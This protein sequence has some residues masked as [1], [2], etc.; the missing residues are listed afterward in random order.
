MR[1]ARLLTLRGKGVVGVRGR[2]MSLEGGTTPGS[3]GQTDTCENITFPQLLCYAKY[4]YL[5][6]SEIELIFDVTMATGGGG[7]MYE[8]DNQDLEQAEN[9]PG[10]S[11]PGSL[12]DIHILKLAKRI[13]SE[14][15]LMDLGIEVLGLK[16]YEI[17]GA[18]TNKKEIQMAAR[19]VLSRW[20]KS[21]K[22]PQE[23]YTNLYTA[24]RK[25]N[26]NQWAVDLKQMVEGVSGT[27]EESR[28]VLS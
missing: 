17:E 6:I 14:S 18:M 19:H 15:K 10:V 9:K 7:S 5:F 23:A 13:T 21:Q 1:T 28:L 26:M 11:V 4:F 8:K 22:T 27:P 25:K 24:L 16:D 3:C 12:T 20:Q 2:G